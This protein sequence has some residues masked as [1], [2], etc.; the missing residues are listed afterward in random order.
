MTQS[1]LVGIPLKPCSETGSYSLSRTQQMIDDLEEK[2]AE[3]EARI[4]QMNSS[5]ASLNKRFLELSELQHVLKE[6]SAFFQEVL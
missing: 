5:A 2:L 6:A 1:E 3:S 4:T